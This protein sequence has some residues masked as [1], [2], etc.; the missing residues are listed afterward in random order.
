MSQE[1]LINEERKRQELL[2]QL[3]K[4]LGQDEYIEKLSLEQLEFIVNPITNSSFLNSCPGSG[5]TEV[6]GFKAAYEASSWESHTSGMAILSFTKSAA[7]EIFGKEPITIQNKGQLNFLILWELWTV[8]YINIYF[9]HFV[10][11]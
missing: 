3:Y 4:R 10:I 2:K 11:C 1:N 6:V 7:S 5:K 8:G 9:N